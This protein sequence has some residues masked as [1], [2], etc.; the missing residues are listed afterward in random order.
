[1]FDSNQD[2]LAAPVTVTVYNRDTMASVASLTFAA[3]NTGVLVQRSLLPL[4]S[5]ITLGPRLPPHRGVGR[6]ERQRHSEQQH[7]LQPQLQRRQRGQHAVVRELARPLRRHRRVSH[8]GVVDCG[9]RVRRRY[10]P[11]RAHL[12][13]APVAPA[14]A[15]TS[16]VTE[17]ASYRVI[18]DYTVPV[19]NS[20][21]NANFALG[22]AQVRTRATTAR[23]W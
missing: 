11:L 12:P 21:F 5:A 9:L 7:R 16:V 13:T 22:S 19:S 10:V 17:A 15:I 23:A 1:M 2:G 6:H 8:H 3:G 18:Y 20:N 4:A 14:A